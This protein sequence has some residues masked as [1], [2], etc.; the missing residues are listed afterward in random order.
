[1]LPVQGQGI[2]MVVKVEKP[3]HLLI[4]DDNRSFREVLRE[5]LEERPLLQ[6]HEAESGEEALEVVQRQRID[7][8]LLDMHMHCMTGLDTIR[9]LK[10]LDAIRP[11]ILITSDTSEDLR[12]DAR[13]ADAWSVLRKPVLRRQLVETVSSA[14][15]SVYDAAIEYPTAG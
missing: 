12:R 1:M 10:K 11:C 6:L 4:T 14:L 13:D 9:V 3:F 5:A 2:A 8:V 15:V 7:I